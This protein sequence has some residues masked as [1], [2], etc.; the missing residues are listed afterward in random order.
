[1]KSSLAW[2]LFLVVLPL[3]LLAA[4][5]ACPPAQAS[6]ACQAAG[7]ATV[8]V[9]DNAAEAP[10]APV[11]HSPPYSPLTCFLGPLLA[12]ALTSRLARSGRIKK[13]TH[14]YFWNIA[15]LAVF[16]LSCSFGLLLAC[17]LAYD[18]HLPGDSYYWILTWH[19][20]AGI[21]MFATGAVHLAR[22]YHY[23]LKLPHGRHE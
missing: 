17:S 14:R 16:G 10:E 8:P 22:R 3:S 21:F 7:L 19:V 1:M 15:L 12:Y 23:F 5:L 20:N 18:W 9:I 11:P 13:S 6:L 2:I 4:P